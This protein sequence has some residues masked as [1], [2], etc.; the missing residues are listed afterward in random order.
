M[1]Y[2]IHAHGH[3]L[4]ITCFFLERLYD[5]THAHASGCKPR[6][7]AAG[8]IEEHLGVQINLILLWR[9]GHFL[10][11]LPTPFARLLE[12]SST[13]KNGLGIDT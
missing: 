7:L 5:Q 9:C 11:L 4:S 3:H 12:I 2:N 10:P 8:L 6:V 1:L 13:S